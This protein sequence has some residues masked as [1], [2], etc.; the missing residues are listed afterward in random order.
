AG[1]P[2]LKQVVTTTVEAGLR[3]AAGQPL[4]WSIGLFRSDNRDDLL[5]VADDAAGFGYFKNYG[6]TRRQGVELGLGGQPAK[7][8]TLG[9]N[10]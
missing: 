3:S 2:P 4:A 8:L 9:A 10:L 1:D 6:R 7:G 5:F